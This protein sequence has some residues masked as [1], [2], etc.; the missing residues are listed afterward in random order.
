MKI[1]RNMKVISSH[2]VHG[3]A[4]VLSKPQQV[5]KLIFTWV[6]IPFVGNKIYSRVSRLWC[7][8]YQTDNTSSEAF[9][10]F[11]HF[12]FIISLS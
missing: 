9:S 11:N 2:Q 4:G 7:A 12:Q 5:Y 6:A 3:L 1:E 8:N 10:N